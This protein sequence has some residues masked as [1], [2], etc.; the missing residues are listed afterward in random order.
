M[1]SAKRIT[2]PWAINPSK[3]SVPYQQPNN[4]TASSQLQK[5]R[6][7]EGQHYRSPTAK[8]KVK[9]PSP[10]NRYLDKEDCLKTP[11]ARSSALSPKPSAAAPLNHLVVAEPQPRILMQEQATASTTEGDG[12]AP[13]ETRRAWRFR[14]ARGSSGE[15]RRWW[16][17]VASRLSL[18]GAQSQQNLEFMNRRKKEA[19]DTAV[20]HFMKT[21]ASAPRRFQANYWYCSIQRYPTTPC[22]ELSRAKPQAAIVNY[23]FVSGSR[24]LT[25]GY[26]KERH[27]C[28][29]SV[30]PLQNHALNIAKR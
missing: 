29:R 16:R 9:P 17:H 18:S 11:T 10:G 15:L 13:S 7:G 26:S 4:H 14:A 28:H 24:T 30:A 6:R 2:C 8:R 3:A 19:K 12:S 23:K 21:D 20:R 25:G 5:R 27:S 1:N 22:H